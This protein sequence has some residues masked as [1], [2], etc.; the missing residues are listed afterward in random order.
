MDRN[1]RLHSDSLFIGSYG[2]S[3]LEKGKFDIIHIHMML[4]IDFDIVRIVKKYN[5]AECKMFLK[6]IRSHQFKGLARHC[7]YKALVTGF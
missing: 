1:K 3:L 4:D 5:Y 6:S 7:V 2:N